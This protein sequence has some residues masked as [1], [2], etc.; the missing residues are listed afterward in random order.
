MIW[1]VRNL[2]KLFAGIRN[3]PDISSRGASTLNDTLSS[4]FVKRT[5]YVQQSFIQP[6]AYVHRTMIPLLH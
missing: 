1:E 6:S 2:R 4:V 3:A 5:S